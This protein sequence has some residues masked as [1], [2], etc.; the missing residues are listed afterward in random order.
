M[1]ASFPG[2][3]VPVM[4]TQLPNIANEMYHEDRHKRH[5]LFGGTQVIQTR[6]YSNSSVLAVVA[7]TGRFSFS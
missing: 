2:E 5:T 1:I 7:R 4:K 3:S 6:F